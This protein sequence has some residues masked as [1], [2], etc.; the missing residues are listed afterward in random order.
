LGDGQV[1]LIVGLGN[2]GKEYDKTRHNVGYDVVD[3]LSEVNRIKVDRIKF[4]ALTGEGTI[5][6]KRVILMKPLTYMNNSGIAVRE[7]MEYYKLNIEELLVIVDDIDIEF[8]ST[9]IRKKGSAGS[10][11]GMK[12]LILHLKRDDFTRI[13]LGIGRKPPEWDLAD[14]VLS[15]FS[16]EERKEV[17]KMVIKAAEAI[18]SILEYGID[19]AMNSFNI[20]NTAQD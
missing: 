16:Q 12:S 3:R 5:A 2:P 1:F 13:K 11:N 15:R 17:D 6:G 14:F 7:A 8:G 18:G 9:R 20:K 4:K 19:T 10:H